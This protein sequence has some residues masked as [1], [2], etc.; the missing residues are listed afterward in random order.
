MK[1]LI[2]TAAFLLVA[3][4]SGVGVTQQP[5][6]VPQGTS[7][8]PE[9]G[10]QGHPAGPVSPG[11]GSLPAGSLAKDSVGDHLIKQI[12]FTGVGLKDAIQG[13]E[14]DCPGFQAVIVPD[15]RNPDFDPVLPNMTL[16]NLP[17]NQI[18]EVIEKSVSEL[19]VDK[20]TSNKG[21]VW[22]FRVRHIGDGRQAAT[23]TSPAVMVCRLSPLIRASAADRAKA[24]SDILALIQAVV[25]ASGANPPPMMKV[26]EPTETL[27]FRGTPVESELITRAL[28]AL[29]ANQSERN[30]QAGAERINAIVRSK[31]A[32]IE[33]IR[34]RLAMVQKEAT[35][36]LHARES[37]IAELKK[38]YGQIQVEEGK[39]LAELKERMRKLEEKPK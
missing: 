13:L 31:D 17:L 25:E 3:T 11:R 6:Q 1:K 35:D 30:S 15:P 28:N 36:T 23:S 14:N 37:E 19:K 27:I 20:V 39:V 4:A 32:E 38:R 2:A 26:H 18:V 7:N 10:R 34:M 12:D 33:Q 29:E 16:K 9:V 24:L 5:V 8:A 21:D 22:I